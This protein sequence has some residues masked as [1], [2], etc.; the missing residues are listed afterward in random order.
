MDPR[1]DVKEGR[2]NGRRDGGGHLLRW[3]RMCS[4]QIWCGL[5]E[6][7]FGNVKFEMPV[8]CPRNNT[9]IKWIK[10]C[11]KDLAVAHFPTSEPLRRLFPLP[12]TLFLQIVAW[13]I[14]SFHSDLC[15]IFTPLE[16]HSLA[17]PHSLQ[18]SSPLSYLISFW[19]YCS[20]ECR[21]CLSCNTWA[22]AYLFSVSLPDPMQDHTGGDFVGFVH[23]FTPASDLCRTHRC[24]IQIC[25]SD[26]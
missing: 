12:R 19:L 11:S 15:L 21:Y 13:F 23:C 22:F 1:W 5:Q 7:R 26:D 9:D 14:S 24:S 16:N 10:T 18:S 2:I 6:L 3:W 17:W 4:E 25:C 8:R 20:S